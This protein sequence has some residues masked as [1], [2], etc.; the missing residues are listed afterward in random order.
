MRQSEESVKL[1]Q[2]LRLQGYVDDI[3]YLY[4][5]CLLVTIATAKDTSRDGAGALTFSLAVDCVL[6]T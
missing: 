1:Q 6:D 4:R 2:L 5:K 3:R